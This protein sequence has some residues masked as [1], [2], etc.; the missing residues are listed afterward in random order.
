MLPTS[1]WLFRL[2]SR[3]ATPYSQEPPTSVPYG[4]SRQAPKDN[5]STHESSTAR[6]P[7]FS[8]SFH[9]NED[10]NHQRPKNPRSQIYHSYLVEP[11]SVR[12]REEFFN[13]FSKIQSCQTRRNGHADPFHHKIMSRVRPVSQ[14]GCSRSP[15]P[16]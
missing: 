6:C 8:D 1:R 15:P 13:L 5:C 14:I 10:K 12:S 3:I 9:R 4:D 16:P 7:R 11:K 2:R